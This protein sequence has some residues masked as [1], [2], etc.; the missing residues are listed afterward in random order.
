MRILP[1]H[2][3]TVMAALSKGPVHA[4]DLVNVCLTQLMGGEAHCTTLLKGK[5][6][7]WGRQGFLS[8]Q[9]SRT[10]KLVQTDDN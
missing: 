8:A 3:A 10:M 5:D 7:C 1:A 9:W 2:Q 4:C 6:S